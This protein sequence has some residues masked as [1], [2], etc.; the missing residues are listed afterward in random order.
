VLGAARNVAAMAAS[1]DI[2]PRSLASSYARLRTRR[3]VGFLPGHARILDWEV[4]YAD[5]SASVELFEEIFVRRHYPFRPVRPSPFVVDCGAN[6]GVS[7]MFFKTLAPQ[8]EILAFEPEPT[9]FRLLCDNVQLNRM[10]TVDCR[11]NAVGG[12]A[13]RRILWSAAPAHGGASLE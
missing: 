7:A 6:I 8:A 9:A 12:E 2:S 10:R 3:A 11:P 5:Y 13:G 1:P 4:A